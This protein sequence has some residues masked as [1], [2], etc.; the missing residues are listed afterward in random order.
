MRAL[1][2][3]SGKAP[4]SLTRLFPEV[5]L[6]PPLCP[7]P[8]SQGV[9]P[10]PHSPARPPGCSPWR[11]EPSC[12]WRD[13]RPGLW[14]G[15]SLHPRPRAG[16]TVLCEVTQRGPSS[17]LGPRVPRPSPP[18]PFLGRE[19]GR[20]SF[21]ARA[22]RTRASAQVLRGSDPAG[23]RVSEAQCGL[24]YLRPSAAGCAPCGKRETPAPGGKLA[25]APVMW[26][27]SLRR[28]PSRATGGRCVYKR[29]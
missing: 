12:A 27:L 11:F 1:G 7:R 4:S 25:M 2:G 13:C 10:G 16:T 8:A 15:V 28:V 23:T 20:L 18:R 6:P 9:V 24:R 21:L 3:C 17:F 5:P 19:T 29:A 22:V 26:G 14:R